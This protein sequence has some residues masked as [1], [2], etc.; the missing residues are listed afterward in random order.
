[1]SNL[2]I[3]TALHRRIDV[4]LNA[5]YLTIITLFHL[6]YAICIIKIRL[7]KNIFIFCIVYDCM[8]ERLDIL[9]SSMIQLLQHCYFITMVSTST[10]SCSSDFVTLRISL[11][12]C[13]VLSIFLQTH[14]QKLEFETSSQ[15]QRRW[16]KSSPS[17]STVKTYPKIKTTW[18]YIFLV[19]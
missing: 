12:Y 18:H 10:A 5:F 16:K 17:S 2:E 6:A 15:N 11:L 19:D 9:V 3:M 8:N 4:S 1:M 14:S 13:L 7:W